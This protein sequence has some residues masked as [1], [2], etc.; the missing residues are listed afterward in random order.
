MMLE[1]ISCFS[2][3]GFGQASKNISPYSHFN[4]ELRQVFIAITR[5]SAEKVFHPYFK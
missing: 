3:W 2:N 5:V 1:V 4:K